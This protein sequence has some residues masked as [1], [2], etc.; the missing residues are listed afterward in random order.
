MEL[1]QDKLDARPFG[2]L[3]VSHM[4]EVD[5]KLIYAFDLDRYV[6]KDE[7]EEESQEESAT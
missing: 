6:R 5:K 3:S 2:R 7:E 4:L 1:P